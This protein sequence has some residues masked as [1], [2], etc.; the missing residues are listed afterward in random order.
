[1]LDTRVLTTKIYAIPTDYKKELSFPKYMPVYI[2][3]VISGIEFNATQI[4]SELIRAWIVDGGLK[5]NFVKLKIK[6]HKVTFL[7]G[8]ITIYGV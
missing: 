1:M 7:S 8:F 2:G 4:G 5:W 6:A 3:K